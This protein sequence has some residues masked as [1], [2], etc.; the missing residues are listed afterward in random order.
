MTIWNAK[1]TIY[2]V[3]DLPRD[4]WHLAS[5]SHKEALSKSLFCE[6]STGWSK[7][8]VHQ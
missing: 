6:K 1:S 8:G 4:F 3:M 7:K 5:K 2:I